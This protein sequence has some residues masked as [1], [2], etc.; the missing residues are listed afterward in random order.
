[1][2]LL[3][4]ADPSFIVHQLCSFQPAAISTQDE[5]DEPSGQVDAILQYV[6]GIFVFIHFE[7]LAA[8]FRLNLSV[9]PPY[10]ADFDGDEMNMQYVHLTHLLVLT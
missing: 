6:C 3:V 7:N 1:M 10:N 9:T 5:Y 8:A 4:L 2:Y